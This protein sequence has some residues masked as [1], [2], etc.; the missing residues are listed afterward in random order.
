[1]P[2][3]SSDEVADVRGRSGY[4][5]RED[6]RLVHQVRCQSKGDGGSPKIEIAYFY[7]SEVPVMNAK[8]IAHSTDD[9]I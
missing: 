9:N 5:R 1:M 3:V 7:S 8:L 2:P 4:V 6:A